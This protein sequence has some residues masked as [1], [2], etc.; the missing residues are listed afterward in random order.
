[1]F[2]SSSEDEDFAILEDCPSEDDSIS[3]LKEKIERH[4]K[5]VTL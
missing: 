2:S 1:M 3:K 4:E 5:E